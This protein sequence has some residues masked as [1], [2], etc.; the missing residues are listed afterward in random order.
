MRGLQTYRN[1]TTGEDVKLDNSYAHAW[2]SG[3]GEY[4][5]SSAPGFNPG[6][7]LQGSWTELQ[8]IRR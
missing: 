5:L 6:Q 1:P 7:V 3:N 8:P 4:V 2:A